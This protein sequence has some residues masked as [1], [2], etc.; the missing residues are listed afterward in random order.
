LPLD[1]EGLLGLLH[2]DQDPDDGF[3]AH[4]PELLAFA[5]LTLASN[6][7]AR[8]DCTLWLVG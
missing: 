1:D 5:R 4:A 8:R 3:V 7:A 2:I 6:E